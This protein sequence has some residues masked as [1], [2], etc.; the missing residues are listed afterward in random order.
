AMRF[1]LTPEQEAF[2]ETARRFLSDRVHIR[3]AIALPGAHDPDLW[4]SIA[5]MGWLGVDVPEEYGG[6]GLT[7]VETALLA[8]E[9]GRALL[10]GPFT[11]AL[12]FTAAITT[13]GTSQQRAE[14]LPVA[15]S[16]ESVVAAH[17][18]A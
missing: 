9:A 1:S 5:A 6:Q 17:L 14:L 8:E 11:G 4:K 16:G 18:D 15:C 2:R 3:E 13:A 12:Q 7:F 10:P